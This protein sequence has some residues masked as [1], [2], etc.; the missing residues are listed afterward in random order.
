LIYSQFLLPIPT[1]NSQILIAL[2][3]FRDPYLLDAKF[4]K[5]V[6]MKRTLLVLTL[7]AA[8]TAG[9]V[10]AASATQDLFLKIDGIQGESLDRVHANEIDVLA[11]SWGAT[12]P[13]VVRAG[14][15]GAGAG[16]GK[17][18][19][20]DLTITKYVDASSPALVAAIS[21]GK[22]ITSLILTVRRA[23]GA[24]QGVDYFT[25]TLSDALVTGVSVSTSGGEDRMTENVTFNYGTF[26]YS[27]TPIK[28]DGSKLSP[29]T[30]KFNIME[31]KLS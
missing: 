10:S 13:S 23:N 20:N 15:A 29:L 21:T 4:L 9:G 30:T 28:K 14:G 19:F 6:N 12:A 16:A 8:I 5:V 2:L 25:L 7:V 22:R 31:G 27:Y 1:L 17:A 24:P 11:W 26:T 3:W 18:T